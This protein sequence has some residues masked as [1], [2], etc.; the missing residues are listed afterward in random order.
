MT[1][2]QAELTKAQETVTKI[3]S[4]VVDLLMPMERQMMVMQW[5]PEFRAIMWEA[6]AREA[7]ARAEKT[8]KE[9][10]DAR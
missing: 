3:M 9:P 10:R 4:M 8:M 2:T 5:A 1:R 6:V 7:I